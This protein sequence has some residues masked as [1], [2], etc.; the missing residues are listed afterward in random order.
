MRT[1]GTSAIDVWT[2]KVPLVFQVSR[3]VVQICL[4]QIQRSN[5]MSKGKMYSNCH[6]VIIHGNI[7]KKDL[8]Q[9]QAHIHLIC[10]I[11]AIVCKLPITVKLIHVLGHLDSPLPYCLL[12]REQKLDLNMTKLAKKI[13]Q[14]DIQNRTCIMSDFSCESFQIHILWNEVSHSLTKALNDS[15][16]RCT[17]NSFY[18][19]EEIVSSVVFRFVDWDE[20]KCA[21]K[22]CPSMTQIS[23]TKTLT[24]F[25]GVNH[26]MNLALKG[27]VD[28]KCPYC[29]HPN[30]TTEHLLPW[31]NLARTKL[32]H[33]SVDKLVQ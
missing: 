16:S 15:V 26:F 22:S 28:A 5:R 12:T 23:Y 20:I 8:S 9:D 4:L 30:H 27:K 21:M 29:L 14:R 7:P 6:G 18:N 2:R 32:Y 10:V 3:S 31:Q 11:R 24:K 25:C 13:L 33:D 17:A 19:L 1:N